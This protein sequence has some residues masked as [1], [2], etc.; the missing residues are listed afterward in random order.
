MAF[1]KPLTTDGANAVI[2]DQGMMYWRAPDGRIFAATQDERDYARKMRRGY[3]PLEQYGFY[4]S[5]AYYMDHP[6]EPLFQAG[7]AREL[8]VEDLLALGYAQRPPLVP[9][10]GQHVGSNKDHLQH[11]ASCW[12]GARPVVFPQLEGYGTIPPLLECDYCGRDDLATDAALKQHQEVMH[13]ERRQEEGLSQAIIEGL[14]KGG[15]LEGGFS[16]EAIAAAVTA[17]LQALGVVKPAAPVEPA[18]SPPASVSERRPRRERRAS[19]SREAAFPA[20]GDLDMEDFEE[21]FPTHGTTLNLATGKLTTRKSDA[22][23]EE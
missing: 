19:A 7:G 21:A 22:D 23:A 2:A 8:K 13:T 5:S 17:T 18:P 14:S 6:H 12:T 16:A 1:D 9:V 10:C 11:R 3:T 20:L 15:A 4:S